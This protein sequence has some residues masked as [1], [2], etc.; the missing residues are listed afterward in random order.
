[1]YGKMMARTLRLAK[2]P[3]RIGNPKGADPKERIKISQ[4]LAEANGDRQ[5]KKLLG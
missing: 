3:T 4:K 1:M 2:K 5:P